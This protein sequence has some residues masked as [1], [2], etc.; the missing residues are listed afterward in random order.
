MNTH[1]LFQELQPVST[2]TADEEQ[3]KLLSSA[4]KQV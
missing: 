4:K 2:E 1:Y 3:A